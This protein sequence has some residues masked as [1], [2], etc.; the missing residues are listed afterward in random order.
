MRRGHDRRSVDVR[1]PWCRALSAAGLLLAAVAVT[2]PAPASAATGYVPA[3]FIAKQYTEALGRMP[4]QPGWQ[5]ASGWFTEHGC[6]ASSLA[7]YGESFFSSSEYANLGYDD[8]AQ[9]VTLY[10]AALNREPD[11]AGFANWTQQLDGGL[12]WTTV[13]QK[14]Y[15]SGEFTAL[16]PRIC[17][18]VVDGSGSS[19]YFGTQPAMAVPTSGAGFTGTQAQLQAA[20]DATPVGGTVALAR[21]ALVTLTAPLTVPAGVTL[22]TTGAPNPRHY[23]ELGRLVRAS[24][25]NDRLVKVEGGARL[26]NVWVDG[27]RGNPDTWNAARDNIFTYGGSG[28]AVTGNRITDS[29][30]PSN[31]YLLGSFD[32]YPCG[33]ETV[34]GNLITA[35]ASDHYANSDWTDGISDSCEHATITGNQVVDAT[36][37]AIVV[38]RETTST[39]QHSVVRDNQV[40]SAGNSMY[41]GLAIDPLYEGDGGAAK[42]FDFSDS[43]IDGNQLWSGPDTHF[44]IGIANGTRAWFAGH[45]GITADTGTG[46]SVTNN[47]TGSLTARVQTGIAVNGMLGTTVSGNSLSLTHISAGRCP[48]VDYAAEIT[49]KYASGTFNP[50]PTDTSFDGCI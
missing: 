20:L 9:L 3:Q 50:T 6:T 25:F 10:R 14:F 32:G 35:Y 16:V 40:L 41:G 38:Y 36:D 23:A 49:A 8:S 29:Q 11:P 31:L 47:S 46:A 34:S 26:A 18:G 21:R 28:T 2:G 45:T 7:S 37:V 4:D 19:Y 43:T 30:G 17:S 44:D 24:T 13:V 5:G 33:A 27:A 42:T 22:T 39:A 15:T 12:S 1:K 48:K